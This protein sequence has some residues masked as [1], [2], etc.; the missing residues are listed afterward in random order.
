MNKK[1]DKNLDQDQY[2]IIFSLFMNNVNK[3][4]ESRKCVDKESKLM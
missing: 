3:M 2:F 1:K 4:N